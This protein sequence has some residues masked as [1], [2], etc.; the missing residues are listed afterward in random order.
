MFLTGYIKVDGQLFY[1]GWKDV[2]ATECLWAFSP[3]HM[4]E[5]YE[6][7]LGAVPKYPVISSH[8]ALKEFLNDGY[9]LGIL[10]R[11]KVS[12]KISCHGQNQYNELILDTLAFAR[13]YTFDKND[14]DKDVVATMGLSV[15]YDFEA[16]DRILSY[17]YTKE[18]DFFTRLD[19]RYA[20]VEIH[21][22]KAPFSLNEKLFA[23]EEASIQYSKKILT[24]TI[25]DIDY[26]TLCESLDMSWYRDD[27]GDKKKYD[28]IETVRD[29]ELRI[30]TPLLKAIAEAMEN[31][32]IVDVS[33][34][35]ETTGLNVY[36]LRRDN[37][38]KDHVVAIPITWI[39]DEGFVIFTDMEH[40]QNIDNDYAVGRLAEIFED[41]EGEREIEYWEETSVGA[42]VDNLEN[43]NLFGDTTSSNE[44]SMNSMNNCVKKKINIIRRFINLIGHNVMFDKRAFIDSNKYFYFNND[45]MQMS[46]NLCSKLVK[47]SNKLKVLTR[48]LFG[49]ETPELSDI[50]GKGNEDKYRF[51]TDKEVAK[52][53]GCADADYTLQVFKVLRKLTPDAMY[54]N[55]Q[56]LDIPLLNILPHSEYNGLAIKEDDAL[57]LGEVVFNDINRLKEFAFKYVGIFIAYN[58]QR[59]AIE[60]KRSAGIF[61]EEEY[62]TALTNINPNTDL[63]YEFEF[64]PSELRK[65]LFE[66][67]KYP[68]KAW[69]TGDKPQPKLDKYAMKKL[70]SEKRKS[71]DAKF[72]RLE[73]DIISS[74]ITQEEYDSLIAKGDKRS[75]KKA[76]SMVLIKAS[77]FN[78]CKYPL[79]LIL[80]KYAELNKEYTAYYKPMQETNME[81]R[82]FKSYSLARIE[83]RRIQNA[84]QTMKG[85]L[86][87]LVQSQ[88]DDY[89]LLDFD[90][91][92]VEYRIMLS[93]A[94]H[95]MMIDRM[96]DPEK[97][98]HTETASLINA[99]P[100][101]KV[102]KSVRKKA[103]GVSFGV[104]YGLGERS[105]CENLFTTINDENLFATRL[106]LAKWE[107]ANRPI[108]DF[109]NAERDNAL[110]ARAM[111]NELRDFM[112]AW[113]RDDNGDYA[114]DNT[115]HRIPKNV[116]FIYD[117]YGFYRTFDLSDVGQDNDAIRRRS[118]GRYDSAESKIR[119]PAGNFPIQCF[120]AELFR[121]ILI[122]FYNRCVKEG[123][124]DKIV[125]HML[126][127]DELLCSVHK[128]IHP[129]FI[130]KIVKESC[131]VTMKGHTKYFVG[132]NIGNTWGEVKDDAREAP[133]YFVDRIIKRWDAG[134]FGTGPFWFN[135]P[136]NEVIKPERAKY[137]DVRINEVIHQVQPNIDNEPINIP[138]I[139]EKFDNYTVRAYVGDYSYNSFT[140][141][142]LS[143]DDLENPE[144]QDR[145]WASRFETWALGYFP[146]GKPL[147]N[148]D[149]KLTVLRRV[150]ENKK[151]EVILDDLDLSLMFEDEDSYNSSNDYW[152]FDVSEC[153]DAFD[154]TVVDDSYED[155]IFMY[156][157]DD[158]VTHADNIADMLKVKTRYKNINVMLE[159]VMVT[160]PKSHLQEVKDYLKPNLTSSGKSIVFKFSE[161]GAERWLTVNESTDWDSFD[162][163]ITDICKFESIIKANN[164]YSPKNFRVV[165]STIIIELATVYKFT[166]CENWL[167]QFEVKKGYSV[168]LKTPVGNSRKLLFN[169]S[170][171]FEQID[172]Y[173][174]KEF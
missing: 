136:W 70:I 168:M 73:K 114:R 88:S 140:D 81:G 154:A 138:L 41:F 97:D 15:I 157:I 43:M 98:Y 129:F 27:D 67:L 165:G 77:D 14:V 48:K 1:L 38:D 40:F 21:M 78:K 55:Y 110:L 79:A 80:Q 141:D 159:Q 92:Q 143:K 134:E 128:S 115:G 118:N 156:E 162:N 74:G 53:Y 69:T 131:M 93:L 32:T 20:G 127:H 17:Q 160:I 170:L 26:Y 60:A 133:V 112:D 106:L 166:N 91:S 116:G 34:D 23:L 39:V 59:F 153:S 123:I 51:L 7:E 12:G 22:E 104:P 172:N 152:S 111:S 13:N 130:Y 71:D 63:V 82:I 54:D 28:S 66:I 101:H 86:K 135:D 31:D 72:N 83:T 62:E 45:T 84:A 108:M 174:A 158:T 150:T 33:V 139:M 35:T 119:R 113:E 100:A 16:S 19:I 103:K 4:D 64:K 85:N 144:I 65:V 61:T 121:I 90:M 46:F 96:K 161:G 122:R 151:A 6:V 171:T 42:S 173:L 29:F 50:L 125:W 149:G 120:A 132:I 44:I 30:M 146:E 145:L 57:A 117:K 109:L 36:N 2:K 11:T 18:G 52:I 9:L 87:A 76:D 169:V 58:K 142:G 94:G 124:A 56:A 105:L 95:M 47:G 8:M 24:K 102:S 147:I 89:Y 137:V 75:L 37:P 163:F 5:A 107:K 148:Y 68:I 155:D 126:I 25:K 10:K 167:R 49:H 99:I 3:Y 164:K